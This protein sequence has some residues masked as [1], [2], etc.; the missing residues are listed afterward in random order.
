VGISMSM[1]MS[2]SMSMFLRTRSEL[3]EP[4]ANS[5]S[6]GQRHAAFSIRSSPPSASGITW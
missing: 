2:V 3:W 5:Y 1:S 4:R 6:E